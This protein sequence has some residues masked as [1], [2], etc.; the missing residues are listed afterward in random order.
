ERYPELFEKSL[1]AV[2]AIEEKLGVPVPEI[3]ASLIAMHFYAVLFH[4]DAQNT[5]KR[6]LR[7]CILCVGGIGVSYML[8]SQIRQR[9][10]DELEIDLS[11]YTETSFNSYDFLISLG[12]AYQ[13][14][15]TWGPGV[16]T[17]EQAEAARRWVRSRGGHDPVLQAVRTQGT[18][19]EFI[20]AFTLA[21]AA[22]SASDPRPTTRTHPGPA[23]RTDSAQI[24]PVL[25]N[26]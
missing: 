6:T 25:V 4:L 23:A 20:E 3:E 2:K 13:I 17:L 19:P 10:R 26:A 12:V 21:S 22:Q 5:R 24:P 15:T 7:V 9:Y 1:K 16:Q 11:D 18:R 8:A 14:R